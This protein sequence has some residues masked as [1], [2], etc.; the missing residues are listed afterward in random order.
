LNPVVNVVSLNEMV[1]QLNPLLVVFKTP[2]N[3]WLAHPFSESRKNTSAIWYGIG[4]WINCH[5]NR[6]LPYGFG[7]FILSNVPLA[8]GFVKAQ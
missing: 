5:V 8:F 3:R 6:L 1:S 7:L 2:I 4:V